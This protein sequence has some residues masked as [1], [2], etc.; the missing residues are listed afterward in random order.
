VTKSGAIQIWDG[1][2]DAAISRG[3]QICADDFG[4]EQH[5]DGVEGEE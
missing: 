5:L 4:P 3:W 1:L 2:G